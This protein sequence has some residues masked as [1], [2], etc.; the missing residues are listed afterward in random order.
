[1]AVRAARENLTAFARPV[2]KQINFNRTTHKNWLIRGRQKWRHRFL[3]HFRP[4]SS[5][6]SS[7]II[8]ELSIGYQT[9]NKCQCKYIL[10]QFS[11]FCSLHTRPVLRLH[12]RTTPKVGFIVAG[13]S[14]NIDGILSEHL[15]PSKTHHRYRQAAVKTDLGTGDRSWA[16][17]GDDD[18][19]S[20][21][22]SLTA[23]KSPR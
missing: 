17:L 23:T 13:V 11:I 19:S 1:M 4:D 16:E 10:S 12:Y 9:Q 7:L 21:P 22:S 5:L 15:T 14:E 8:D 18:G 20:S 3:G 6:H 2:Q